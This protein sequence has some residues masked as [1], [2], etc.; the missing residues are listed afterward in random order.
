MSE[1]SYHGATSRSLSGLDE[2]YRSVAYT[3]LLFMVGLIMTSRKAVSVSSAVCLAK[4]FRANTFSEST[5][6]LAAS[7]GNS[8]FFNISICKSN[9]T[10]LDISDFVYALGGFLLVRRHVI[11]FFLREEYCQGMSGQFAILRRYVCIEIVGNHLEK[12]KPFSLNINV[13]T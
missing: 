10:D 1:R 13:T 7:W 2:A 9:S 6:F 4:A 8:G 5:D 11:L 12:L 3:Q